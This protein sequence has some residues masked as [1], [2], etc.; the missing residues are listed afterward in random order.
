MSSRWTAFI[1][2]STSSSPTTN[3]KID[4][5]YVLSHLW[6]RLASLP[7][8]T[9]TKT[10]T[11][12]CHVLVK[13]RMLYSM[14]TSRSL[15]GKW[16]QIFRS[17]Q[18]CVQQTPSRPIEKKLNIEFVPRKWCSFAVLYF[19]QTEIERKQNNCDIKCEPTLRNQVPYRQ[20]KC[21]MSH[22]GRNGA[23]SVTRRPHLHII[24]E[25]QLNRL[26]AVVIRDLHSIIQRKA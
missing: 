11:L 7:A 25:K 16:I 6:K 20:K 22:S 15:E 14:L 4:S 21:T 12:D 9:W 1:L 2:R 8:N 5:G 10:A 13:D 18:A 17:I 23:L 24:V 26:D 3:Y 19:A